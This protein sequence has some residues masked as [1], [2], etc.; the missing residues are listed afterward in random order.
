VLS[1][2]VM[3]SSAF[4]DIMPCRPL[5][6]GQCFRGTLSPEYAEQDTSMKAG[7]KQWIL[8]LLLFDR[9]DGSDMF[10]W[11]IG[12]FSMDYVA[13]YPEATIQLFIFLIVRAY[14]LMKCNQPMLDTEEETELWLKVDQW[15]HFFTFKTN[16]FACE[17][18]IA[19]DLWNEVPVKITEK[20]TQK[21]QT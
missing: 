5:K 19:I 17:Q 18:T 13:L 20:E 8:L 7:G 1:T 2:V 4:W 12:W 6:D 3:K 11:N 9:E 21:F 14:S 15:W 16:C 10:L